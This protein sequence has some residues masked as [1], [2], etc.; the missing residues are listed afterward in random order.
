M[1]AVVLDQPYEF[2]PPYRGR[3]WPWFLQKFVRRRLRRSYGIEGFQV[4]GL[5]RLRESIHAGHSIV[6]APN[7]CRPADPLVVTELCRLAGVSP[8]TM[9]SWHVFMQS[10]LQR[11]ILRRIGAFSVYREG[12][13]RQSLDAAVQIL[14]AGRRPLVVFPEGAISRT[15]DRLLALMDGV[16][17]LA[18]S[19]A[20]KLSS[21]DPPRKVVVIPVAI[22]YRFHGDIDAA[23]NET[24]DSIEQ[25]LSWRPVRNQ[26]SLERIYRV[27]QALLWLKEIEYLGS[28]QTGEISVRLEQLID[29]ILAPMELEWRNGATEST[30]VARVKQLRMA[31]LPDM[32]A[33]TVSQEEKDRRWDQLADM[34]IAQQLSHYPPEYVRRH[35]A[36][37]RLLETVER[38]EE[39]LTDECRI[40]RPMSVEVHIGT[41]IEVGAKRQRGVAEDPVTAELNRQLHE[42]LGIPLPSLVPAPGTGPDDNSSRESD[43]HESRQQGNPS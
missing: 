39:D 37:E 35:P 13:D 40:H 41:E 26:S 28:P 1:H 10:R 2:I 42:L 20:K 16:S 27:G 4:Q 30:T 11:F 43:S 25:R 7:H 24:L 9:A 12:M 14:V 31:I 22:R 36:P 34:Y 23:V 15:N 6:L 3:L 17:F 38:F 18:R 19:A 21:S 29:Q 8:L 5:E 33:D 32:V